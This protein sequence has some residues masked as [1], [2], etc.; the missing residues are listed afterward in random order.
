MDFGRRNS[1]CHIMSE[2][3]VLWEVTGEENEMPTCLE[4]MG[5]DMFVHVL[6]LEGEM[7]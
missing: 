7:I 5:G 4:G 3:F 1:S 6:M 2:G